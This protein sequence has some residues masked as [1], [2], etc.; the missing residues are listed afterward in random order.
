M[1][2]RQEH[3]QWCKDRA[4]EYVDSGDVKN[5]WASMESDLSKH[6]ETEGHSAIP[7]GLSLLIN[8][9]LDTPDEMRKFINGFN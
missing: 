4:L 7:L 8:G 1:A 3:L 2:T 6:E 9:N 5:A